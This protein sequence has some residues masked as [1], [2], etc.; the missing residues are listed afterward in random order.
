MGTWRNLDAPFRNRNLYDHIACRDTTTTNYRLRGDGR[1]WH[2]GAADLAIRPSTSF[3]R[4]QRS[5]A[6]SV[7][8]ISSNWAGDKFR[9]GERAEHESHPNW[10]L[11][12]LTHPS[13]PQRPRRCRLIGNA[14]SRTIMNSKHRKLDHCNAV[15]AHIWTQRHRLWTGSIFYWIQPR[16]ALNETCKGSIQNLP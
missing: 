6:V 12:R 10:I 2:C 7:R 14:N 16:T 5:L 4:V 1:N 9:T 8:S 13:S 11:P 15:S 3:G